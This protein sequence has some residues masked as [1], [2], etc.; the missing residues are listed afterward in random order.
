M[1]LVEGDEAT[2]APLI[3]RLASSL[4]VPGSLVTSRL[5]RLECRT[6]PLRVDDQATLAQFEL[7]FA[8][9]ELQ[10]V[11]VTAAVLE[12]ATELRARYNLRTPDAIHLATAIEACAS[13]FLTGDR[14]MSK[15]QEI[16]VEVL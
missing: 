1:R 6:K 4:G 13:I 11:E 12:R 15:C 5:T 3:A 7:F 9:I 8:G 16:V 14:A 2:R 10:M